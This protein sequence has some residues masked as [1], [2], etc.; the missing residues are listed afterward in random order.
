MSTTVRT[1]RPAP[2]LFPANEILKLNLPPIAW[3]LKGILPEGFSV[4]GGRQ[5]LGK[6]TLALKIA[7]S[8]AL[9]EPAMG[10]P[11]PTKGDV[12]YI[13]IE[14]G[15]RRVQKRLSDLLGPEPLEAPE[16]LGFWFE[17]PKLDAG[18]IDH[19]EA[20]RVSKASPKM[21]IVDVLQAIKPAGRANRTAYENDYDIWR[22]LQEW[23]KKTGVAVLGL[24]HTRKQFSEDPLESLSGSNGLSA[25]ADTCLILDSKAGSRTLYVRG[26][27][28]EECRYNLYGFGTGSVLTR[29]DEPIRLAGPAERVLNHLRMAQR[30]FSVAEVVELAGVSNANGRQLLSRLFRDGLVQKTSHGRYASVEVRTN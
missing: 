16:A 30:D 14:N 24:H 28:V 15:K 1:S 10:L 19:L 12:L 13:D 25:C 6:S 7:V 22:P 20:W 9:G 4:L 11:A 3:V 23:S 26:R 17:A 18:L 5:K 2:V 27:D 29:A 21:V 8:V